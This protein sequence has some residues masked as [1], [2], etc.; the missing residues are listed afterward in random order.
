MKQV[1]FI[2]LLFRQV[3]LFILIPIILVMSYSF[4]MA[5]RAET[6]LME[7]AIQARSFAVASDI[8]GKLTRFQFA[9]IELSRNKGLN[10]VAK[11]ILYSQFVDKSLQQFVQHYDGIASAFI[12]D[13]K[14]FVVAGYPLSSLHPKS[15]PLQQLVKSKILSSTSTT[16]PELHYFDNETL[17]VSDPEI[18][19]NPGLLVFTT[20]LMRAT[21]SLIEPM[22]ANAVLFVV[23]SQQQLLQVPNKQIATQS[24]LEF[25]LLNSP[26]Q[27]LT[28]LNVNL[29]NYVTN[30]HLLE[31]PIWENDRPLPLSVINYHQKS[32]YILD[33]YKNIAITV[34]ALFVVFIVSFYFLR[35]WMKKLNRPIRE[36]V[37]LSHQIAKGN[38]K[39][40][41]EENP[42]IEFHQI[43]DA[44]NSM[45][46]QISTQMVDLHNARRLAE[47]SDK[48]KSQFLANMSHEIRTPMNGV[49][50]VL[51]LLKRQISDSKQHSLVDTAM[52]SGQN[53][54]RILND[55]LDFSKIE[56]EQLEI[57]NVAFNPKK[58]IEEV[59]NLSRVSCQ[60]KGLLFDLSID[61]SLN[62]EWS[63]DYLRLS[64]I[65]YNLLSNAIKFTQ[66][67]RVSLEASHFQQ[68]G[69][70]LL[71]CSVTDQGIGIN[72]EQLR[73]LFTPFKQADA[74]T[75]RQ[76]GG[77]GLGLV[78]CQRLVQLM[79]GELTVES[80]M[81]EGSCFTFFIEIDKVQASTINHKI[82]EQAEM[83]PLL[84]GKRILVAEDNMIN[85]EIIKLMLEDTQAN[86]C[87]VE[88]GEAVIEAM[89]SFQPDLILMDVQMP[90]MDGIEATQVLRAKKHE[91]PIIMLTAN[92]SSTDVNIYLAGG[93]N[94]VLGKPTQL[95]ELY[96]IL[97]Q[98]LN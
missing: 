32:A 49:L 55:I 64:Q 83:P 54:M 30:H 59:C 9:T 72:T 78:I 95:S 62:Q 73:Y 66:Q 1:P 46:Q 96:N 80:K 57:E 76:F 44:L 51:Q 15:L 90:V 58:I 74:S 35:F 50:G 7:S 21:Q 5:Y 23:L 37:Q 79:N 25:N 65:L 81:G 82:V 47:S 8:N 12:M 6:T 28:P 41:A 26:T 33:V 75:T 61:E 71:R 94:H 63:G 91:L 4:T 27:V 17:N 29:N 16:L 77:T 98:Y 88:D 34:L 2:T 67:G 31:L 24:L 93:A 38:Y 84:I 60:E 36:M 3:S 92:V 10:E 70:D 85:Q 19:L 18:T 14:G 53:L 86:I 87:L 43:H 42:Y 39:L 20:T 48:L 69:R 56:A 89:A 40:P 52:K 11:N 13:E 22:E 45:A 68:E 97:R